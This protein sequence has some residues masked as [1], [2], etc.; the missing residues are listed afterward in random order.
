M[1]VKQAKTEIDL[2]MGDRSC[3]CAYAKGYLE[4]IEQTK[5]LVEGLEKIKKQKMI[6]LSNNMADRSMQLAG[7]WGSLKMIAHD[8]LRDYKKTQREG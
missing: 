6:D 8:V 7:M 5:P 1:N 4:A 2:C 3:N